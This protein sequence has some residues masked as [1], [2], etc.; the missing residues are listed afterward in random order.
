MIDKNTIT[1][2]EANVEKMRR[3]VNVVVELFVDCQHDT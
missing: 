3:Q 1:S 2:S